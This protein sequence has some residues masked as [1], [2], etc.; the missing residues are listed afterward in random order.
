MVDSMPDEV[1]TSLN[2]SVPFPQRLGTPEEF[3]ETVKFILSNRYLNGS[4]IRLD[5]AVRLAAK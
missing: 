5:G 3:A 4:T 2:A 1:R